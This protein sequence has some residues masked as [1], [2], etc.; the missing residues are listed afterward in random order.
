M[1]TTMMVPCLSE[2]TG[3]EQYVW[4]SSTPYLIGI[5]HHKPPP[6]ISEKKVEK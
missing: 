5:K 6:V 1:I 2:I 3:A 4:W